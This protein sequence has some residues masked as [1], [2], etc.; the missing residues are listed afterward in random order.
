MPRWLDYLEDKAKS[1]AK[2]VTPDPIEQAVSSVANTPVG[3]IAGQTMVQ[4]PLALNPVAIALGAS[5]VPGVGNPAVNAVVRPITSRTV[6][7]LIDYGPG[8]YMQQAVQQR[9][10]APLNPVNIARG[11]AELAAREARYIAGIPQRTYN[12]LTGD[13]SENMTNY[14]NMMGDAFHDRNAGAFGKSALGFMLSA[15]DPLLQVANNPVRDVHTWQGE[16]AYYVATHNGDVSSE[17]AAMPFN[18]G[19]D[20]AREHPEEWPA[21]KHAYENGYDSDGDG[22]VDFHG[23]RAVWEYIAGKMDRSTRVFADVVNDPWNLTLLAGG[24]ESA[25]AKGAESVAAN[26]PRMARALLGASRAI[27]ASDRATQEVLN[28]PLKPIELALKAGLRSETGQAVAHG[29]GE[30][31]GRIAR[32]LGLTETEASKAS[33]LANQTSSFAGEVAET[34]ALPDWAVP[35]APTGRYEAVL[36]DRNTG[37]SYVVDPEGKPVPGSARARRG[38]HRENQ[39]SAARFNNGLDEQAQIAAEAEEEAQ[40]KINEA[41]AQQQATS[42]NAVSPFDSIAAA[43]D[44]QLPPRV[45]NSPMVDL[46]YPRMTA[47]PFMSRPELAAPPFGS[48]LPSPDSPLPAATVGQ[49]PDLSVPVGQTPANGPVPSVF[50]QTVDQRREAVNQGVS[51]FAPNL[52]ELPPRVVT[53]VYR[54]L[55][56]KPNEV[57][58]EFFRRLGVDLQ[59]GK[60]IAGSPIELLENQRV[61]LGFFKDADGGFPRKIAEEKLLATRFAVDVM[62]PLYKDVTGDVRIPGLTR[63]GSEG[64]PVMASKLSSTRPAEVGEG[65]AG[66]LEV[67]ALS[68]QEESRNLAKAA[69]QNS[70]FYRKDD[71]IKAAED[72]NRRVERLR[73]GENVGISE[74]WGRIVTAPPRAVHPA[75][76]ERAAQAETRQWIRDVYGMP[77]ERYDRLNS[78]GVNQ[79]NPFIALGDRDLIDAEE[80]RRELVDQFKDA[81]AK[82][83]SDAARAIEEKLWQLDAGIESRVAFLDDEGN[84]TPEQWSDIADRLNRRGADLANATAVRDLPENVFPSRDPNAPIPRAPKPSVVK[85]GL[86]KDSQKWMRDKYGLTPDREQAIFAGYDEAIPLVA[87]TRDPDIVEAELKRRKLVKEF[88]ETVYDRNSYAAAAAEKAIVQHDAEYA[89]LVAQKYGRGLIPEN[90]VNPLMAI[91]DRRGTPI[92][93]PRVNLADTAIPAIPKDI[94]PGYLYPDAIGGSVEMVYSGIDS[95]NNILRDV[96]NPILVNAERTRIKIVDDLDRALNKGDKKAIRRAFDRLIDHDTGS[97]DL[98]AYMFSDGRLSLDDAIATSALYRHRYVGEADVPLEFLIPKPGERPLELLFPEAAEYLRRKEAEAATGLP[99]VAASGSTLPAGSTPEAADQLADTPFGPPIPPELDPS[100]PFP[101]PNP[102]E[103]EDG[104]LYGIAE[105]SVQL[106]DTPIQGDHLLRESGINRA[107]LEVSRDDLQNFLPINNASR[108]QLKNRGV[109]LGTTPEATKSPTGHLDVMLV[110]D[111]GDMQGSFVPGNQQAYQQ[112]KARI[113]VSGPEDELANKLR[114]IRIAPTA[115][116]PEKYPIRNA[117]QLEDLMRE[118]RW[119]RDEMPDGTIV[120]RRP[121]TIPGAEQADANTILGLPKNTVDPNVGHPIA[122]ITD[123][124]DDLYARGLIDDADRDMLNQTFPGMD[125]PLLQEIIMMQQ[126]GASPADVQRRIH[127][128]VY[129]GSRYPEKPVI[130]IIDGM[131]A[132]GVIDDTERDFLTRIYPGMEK[133]LFQEILS[134]RRRGVKPGEIQKRIR[135][136]VYNGPIKP[137]EAKK[138]IQKATSEITKQR[139]QA[140]QEILDGKRSIFGRMAKGASTYNRSVRQSQMYNIFNAIPGITGDLVGNLMHLQQ[141][142]EI[143]TG[144]RFLSPDNLWLIMG[145]DTG[146]AERFSRE[147]DAIYAGFN[148]NPSEFIIPRETAELGAKYGFHDQNLVL[149]GKAK[150]RA[151]RSGKNV[152]TWQKIGINVVQSPVVASRRNAVDTGSRG[153]LHSTTLDGLLDR[154][155]DEFAKELTA[156]GFPAEKTIEAIRFHATQVRAPEAFR[157]KNP[158]GLLRSF[159]PDDVLAVTGHE[160][161][162]RKWR[163]RQNAMFRQADDK[164]RELFFADAKRYG[165]D[166]KVSKVFFYHFWQTRS[167]ALQTRSML[168]NPRVLGQYY[169]MIQGAMNEADEK[170]YP[171]TFRGLV[172]YLG[173]ETG[174]YGLFNPLGVLIPG[175]M[176]SDLAFQNGEGTFDKF[177]SILPLTPMVSAAAAALGLTESIPNLFGTARVQNMIAGI[178]NYGEAHGIDFT[179][180]GMYQDPVQHWTQRLLELTN[181]KAGKAISQKRYQPYEPQSGRMDTMRSIVYYDATQDF[182]PAT[183]WTAA[184]WDEVNEALESL[185]RGGDGNE[186]AERAFAEYSDANMRNLIM[187]SLLPQGSVLRYGPRE[188]A[189]NATKRGDTL[190]EQRAQREAWLQRNVV[191]ASPEQRSIIVST[192]KLNLLGTERQKSLYNDYN[193]IVYGVDDMITADDMQRYV[194]VGGQRITVSQLRQMSIDERKLVAKAFVA[195]RGGTEELAEYRDMRSAEIASNPVMA[196]FNEY[197]TFVRSYQN[198]GVAGFRSWAETV[199]PEFDRRQ[200]KRRDELERRGIHGQAL[201]AELND[202]ATSSDAFTAFIGKRETIYD[203]RPLPGASVAN[204]PMATIRGGGAWQPGFGASVKTQRTLADRITADMQAYQQNMAM[205]QGSTAQLPGF[206]G[207]ANEMRNGPVPTPSRELAQYIMWAQ[208]QPQGADVSPEAFEAWVNARMAGNSVAQPAMQAATAP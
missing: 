36:A 172:H 93:A 29:A 188:Q 39:E 132:R 30:I 128:A 151:V 167:L 46:A 202:W 23:S 176:F 158:N 21:I 17:H 5:G 41:R 70:S 68:P 18:I 64:I 96:K 103:F 116:R 91:I 57:Q 147:A 2:A 40:A 102:P 159:S 175:M 114:E 144:F 35:K 25:L 49:G 47:G 20:W 139:R 190:A 180:N 134:M 106:P 199:S 81:A 34:T 3:R 120:Y 119:R 85:T 191:Q 92:Y 26:S 126:Q 143:K 146:V 66:L 204:D 101:R 22:T 162:A 179:R 152:P 31:A 77:D 87:M 208:R 148:R 107:Y 130:E 82:R 161:L 45:M 173:D 127:A 97:A 74:E 10:I 155:V 140:Q 14:A 44:N 6:E 138:A 122:P 115:G 174:F 51:I 142:G 79:G 177:G 65:A 16:G 178:I 15:V 105:P 193:T 108:E 24:A 165:I 78:G 183:G 50:R 168:R 61:N 164:V 145:G 184:Q 28:L 37:A 8:Q 33:R 38:A 90:V 12:Y 27:G 48:E 67:I 169:R 153:V 170:G 201:E 171:K 112:G 69:L 110:F 99:E 156:A 59:T 63:R 123:L 186:R 118:R 121:D 205:Y 207:M 192:Q 198:G 197:K 83:D 136:A 54:E 75:D 86:G 113:E 4:G 149:W 52:T 95:Y 98:A 56:K 58:Q 206:W 129:S 71:F 133:P 131:H 104:A 203:A 11:N 137:E 55:R 141:A 62:A 117:R 157:Q 84:I 196:D 43:I 154:E 73:R 160:N 60:P 187:G 80:L 89:G 135:L 100:K 1:A 182:G 194:E 109:I 111:S 42:V 13:Y 9:S 163:T 76:A 88:R 195:E 181:D 200:Q 7:P 32:T 185:D 125:Q 94:R 166:D 53:D 19:V 72:I 124:A 189:R 150:D